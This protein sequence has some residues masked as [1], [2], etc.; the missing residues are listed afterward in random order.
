MLEYQSLLG[1]FSQ[2]AGAATEGSALEEGGR[3]SGEESHGGWWARIESGNAPIG[4]FDI[5]GY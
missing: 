5:E 2:L 4:R 3:W 1:G